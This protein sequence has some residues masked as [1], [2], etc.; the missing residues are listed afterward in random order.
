MGR[1]NFMGNGMSRAF[2]AGLLI[3]LLA[4]CTHQH[5]QPAPVVSKPI[6]FTQALPSGTDALRKLRVDE[7]P[8]FSQVVTNDL[9]TLQIALQHSLEYLKTRGSMV[10]PQIQDFT[11]ERSVATLVL[12]QKLLD[13]EIHSPALDGGVRFNEAIKAN[14]DV[15]QSVGAVDPNNGSYTGRVLFTGYY[16]PT[17]DASPVRTD[18]FKYPLYKRP[19]DLWTDPT[20]EQ[21]HRVLPDGTIAPA[22]TREQIEQ[23]HV[24]DGDE[25]VWLN[26]RFAAYI[27]TVQGSARLRMPD[28]KI[29][30]AGYAGNNGYPYMPIG[31]QMLAD[32]VIKPDQL[33]LDG[34]KLYFAGHPEAMDHYLPLNPRTVFFANRPGGPYGSLNQPVTP[35]ATLATD[36]SIFPRALPVFVVAPLPLANG[37]TDFRGIMFDQDT[38]GAIRAAGRADIYMGL[39]DQAGQE[40]NVGQMYYLAIKTG[41]GMG[42]PPMQ[43]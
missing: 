23:Q 34:L 40:L 12:L 5:P 41:D 18:E 22:Y 31:R 15:Y 42:V 20:G 29:L 2:K 7:Y 6:D 39:G 17:Y 11:H 35:F 43:K 28:G 4:G 33:S 3:S 14:F 25:F 37:M 38:G 32:G 1:M 36:K 13:T 16:T 10:A 27:I 21:A 30:E 8:D 9:P 19:V 24:L 26:D